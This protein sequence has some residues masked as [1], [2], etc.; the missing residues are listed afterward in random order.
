MEEWRM[1]VNYR[2]LISDHFFE[3]MNNIYFFLN[4]KFLIH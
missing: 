2:P 4:A 3:L 1:E